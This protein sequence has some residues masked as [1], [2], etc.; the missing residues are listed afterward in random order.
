[1]FKSIERIRAS[2]GISRL[3]FHWRKPDP[4]AL[5]QDDSWFSKVPQK[6]DYNFTTDLLM[7]LDKPRHRSFNRCLFRTLTCYGNTMVLEKPKHIG[8]SNDVDSKIKFISNSLKSNDNSFIRK[9]RLSVERA[10]APFYIHQQFQMNLLTDNLEDL[11]QLY[12]QLPSPR[13]MYLKR[14][15]LEKFI[16]M[17]LKF[18]PRSNPELTTPVIKVF[19]DLFYKGGK[20]KLS[21]S[22]RV[23]L[24]SLYAYRITQIPEGEEDVNKSYQ[25]LNRVRTTIGIDKTNDV[26][27]ILNTHFPNHSKTI[28]SDMCKHI[29]VNR[30]VLPMILK[31]TRSA[32]QLHNILKLVKM[33]NIHID[34]E[35]INV[36]IHQFLSLGMIDDSIRIIN[37]LIMKFSK[38]VNLMKSWRPN[39]RKF[40][41]QLNILNLARNGNNMTGNK[42]WMNGMLTP[43]PI[44]PS[45]LTIGEVL[46]NE[47]I[48]NEQFLELL[49]NVEING[50]PLSY[51]CIHTLISQTEDFDSLRTILEILLNLEDINTP[52]I[53]SNVK[54]F[55]EQLFNYENKDVD[56][57]NDGN[58]INNDILDERQWLL[59]ILKSG[60][61]THDRV[62]NKG[63]KEIDELVKNRVQSLLV[64]LNSILNK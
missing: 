23:K 44:S 22:E 43:Y 26:W 60:V 7:E 54:E 56:E 3:P 52:M 39:G 38:N 19:E 13:P 41:E 8:E 40:V 15:E 45:P 63:T 30:V 12:F 2:R 36:I 5:V 57:S 14:N 37:G 55:N 1:M 31:S 18:N 58:E 35:L 64:D 20:I 50:I 10:N 16:V 53:N 27:I 24:F 21:K 25:F 46:T 42:N 4:A 59:K 9:Q 17:L 11:I 61:E 51:K 48:S 33:K 62:I 34:N 47:K 6:L 32:K 29:G 49:L 28:T